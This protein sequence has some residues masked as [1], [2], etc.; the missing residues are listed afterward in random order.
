MRSLITALTAIMVTAVTISTGPQTAHADCNACYAGLRQIETERLRIISDLPG[1]G[2]ALLACYAS[3]QGQP[4]DQKAGC[5]ITACGLTCLSIGFEHCVE[6]VV[7]VAPLEQQSE[8]QK[9]YCRLH[10]CRTTLN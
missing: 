8:R 1:T 3:C 5:V 2:A 10:S 7:R 6:F 9:T 4:E